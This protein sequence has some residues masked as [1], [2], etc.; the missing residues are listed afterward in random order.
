MFVFREVTVGVLSILLIYGFSDSR[1]SD[2][3]VRDIRVFV[4]FFGRYLGKKSRRF[5]KCW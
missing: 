4:G 3:V 1:V 2:D 5:E